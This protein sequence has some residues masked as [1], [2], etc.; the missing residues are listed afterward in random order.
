MFGLLYNS[1]SYKRNIKHY[2]AI[3]IYIQLWNTGVIFYYGY[4]AGSWAMYKTAIPN[5][6]INVIYIISIKRLI[7]VKNNSTHFFFFINT[8]KFHFNP[9]NIIDIIYVH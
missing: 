3:K 1:H 4:D 2:Y 7:L 5:S 6:N 8:K 9:D